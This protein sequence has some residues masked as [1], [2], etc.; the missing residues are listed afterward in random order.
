MQLLIYAS[1]LNTIGRSL[2]KKINSVI[3]DAHST[4]CATLEALDEFLRQ[5]IGASPIGILIPADE[6]ELAALVGMRHL[7]RDMRLI[8]VLP[9]NRALGAG[10]INAHMLRP[11]FI[12][13]ADGDPADITA[14]LCKMKSQVSCV[15]SSWQSP[16]EISNHP[17]GSC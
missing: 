17:S 4:Y 3:V 1:P 5:P 9:G 2:L 11:R 6:G 12:G 8:L 7:L 10:T 14:V 15:S 16:L 13:Y